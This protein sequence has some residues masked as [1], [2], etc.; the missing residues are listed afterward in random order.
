MANLCEKLLTQCIGADCAN[1]IYSGVESVAWI[2]NKSEATFTYDTTYP[3][4][5][6]A[7]TLTSGAALYPVQQL[8]KTPFTGTTTSLE[9]GNVSN[10]FTNNFAFVVPDNSVSAAEILDNLANGKFF[11]I[12]KNEYNGSDDTGTFQVYGAKKGLVASA[13][14][15]DKYSEDTD[16]GWA[17]TL[18][19]TGTPN[20]ALF[21]VYGA[22]AAETQAYIDTLVAD[23]GDGSDD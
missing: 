7:I 3:N 22:D 14:D 11:A 17:I 8:G 4:T 13:I 20:S 15:N 5:I 2:G 9:E 19:E 23:C 12:I 1:P 6:T 10:K 16:G 18:T 21:L